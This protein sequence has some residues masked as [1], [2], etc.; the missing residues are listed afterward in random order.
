MKMFRT[1][2]K[3]LVI[4]ALLAIGCLVAG[5]YGLFQEE[6]VLRNYQLAVE[7]GGK[8]CSPLW[9]SAGRTAISEKTGHFFCQAEDLKYLI[10]LAKGEVTFNDNRDNPYLD[11]TVDYSSNK[12]YVLT[13]RHYLNV[14]D[15]VTR[16][17]II[18]HDAEV[19]HRYVPDTDDPYA[20]VLIN[21]GMTR[22]SAGRGSSVVKDEY[23]D[24]TRLLHDVYGVSVRFDKDDEARLV[25]LHFDRSST[26]DR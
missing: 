8:R 10:A 15:S 13:S 12:A 25:T 18:G 5:Y 4:A 16:Y 7:M 6:R 3:L 14:V 24:A 1:F 19:A 17:D 20:R 22:S 21:V 11:G 9:L 26:I 23:L 2:A